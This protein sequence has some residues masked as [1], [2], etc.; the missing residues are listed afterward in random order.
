MRTDSGR[1]PA[2]GRRVVRRV[3]AGGREARAAREPVSLRAT[4]LLMTLA[5]G[6]YAGVLPPRSLR[7]STR[8][9]AGARQK[10][11]GHRR[12]AGRPGTPQQRA[13]PCGVA[14]EQ[15][16]RVP[17]PSGSGRPRYHSP[18]HRG[19]SARRRTVV[20]GGARGAARAAGRSEEAV[21]EWRARWPRTWLLEPVVH[22]PGP[23]GGSVRSTA[24]TDRDQQMLAAGQQARRDL[25]GS[26]QAS[27]SRRARCCADATSGSPR[28]LG[29]WLPRST[30]APARVAALAELEAGLAR[31]AEGDLTAG[32]PVRGAMSWAGWAQIISTK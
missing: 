29:A 25:A 4:L 9:G 15:P 23:P 11:R 28:R 30:G 21:S 1:L 17:H 10:G 16:R 24:S 27:S 22:G 6:V 13:A 3:A 20:R 32:V 7:A 8:G 2:A 26:T 14:R 19:A 12:P 5:A 18:L 31:V